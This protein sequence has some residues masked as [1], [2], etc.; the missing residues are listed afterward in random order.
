MLNVTFEKVK[1][2]K[3]GPIDPNEQ[4]KAN[5]GHQEA[6]INHLSSEGLEKSAFRRSPDQPRLVSHGQQVLPMPKVY[7]DLNRHIIPGSLFQGSDLSLPDASSPRQGPVSPGDTRFDQ[8][9][10]GATIVNSKLKEEVIREVFGPTPVHHKPRKRHLAHKLHRTDSLPSEAQKLDTLVTPPKHTAASASFDDRYL[11]DN[12]EPRAV[13]AKS[14]KREGS[15][16]SQCLTSSEESPRKT[17][18]ENSAE[19]KA[20]PQ[21]LTKRLPRR[22]ASTAALRRHQSGIDNQNDGHLEFFD[23]DRY[24]VEADDE[25]FAMEDEKTVDKAQQQSNPVNRMKE[26]S[27]QMTPRQLP[28]KSQHQDADVQRTMLPSPVARRLGSDVIDDVPFNPK[29]ARQQGKQRSEEFILL[30][31]LTS[32]LK[33]PCTLDLKM[34]TRQHGIDANEQKQRSQRM[35]CKT[36]TSR[37]LGVR[38]CGMQTFDVKTQDYVWQDKYYGR[39]LKAGREFQEALT[40][41][42]W[43][44]VNHDAA[45][46]FIPIFLENI[47][48]LERLIKNLPG[49]RFYGSSL[50]IIYDGEASKRNQSRS[51]MRRSSDSEEGMPRPETEMPEPV[52]LFKIIDFANCV[53]AETTDV[54]NVSCPPAYTSG[55]DRGYLRGLRT[56]RMYFRRIWKQVSREAAVKRGEGEN[57]SIEDSALVREDSSASWSGK[58]SQDDAGEVST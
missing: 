56:L 30:E 49:Y 54:S 45:R 9:S 15:L 27:D 58:L 55:V 53:T 32:G 13:V 19:N 52:F 26:E 50:Y 2:R 44:G 8:R 20:P 17:H 21:T 37:E 1:R 23:E 43:N 5:G 22:R 7:L 24:T 18:H 39:D 28:Q 47:N 46:R 41:F 34:G 31:D 38:V 40:A 48:A 14:R 6:S 12:D 16:L 36:T 33:N 4:H 35:K 25:M 29:E 10:W 11:S 3:L 42:F 51:R 57:V